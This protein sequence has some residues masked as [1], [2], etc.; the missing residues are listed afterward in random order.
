MRQ[1]SFLILGSVLL[2]LAWV[3][4]AGAAEQ[5]DPQAARLGADVFRSHCASCHGENAKGDGEV[6]QYLDPKPADLTLIMKRRKTSEFPLET[7]VNIIDGRVKVAGH[8][9][10]EMP[11]WGDAFLVADGGLDSDQVQKKIRTLAQYLWSI[12]EKP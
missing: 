3:A 6:A 4:A 12:Q 9:R 7:V 10:S 5:F 2:T 8:G 1:G 11:V